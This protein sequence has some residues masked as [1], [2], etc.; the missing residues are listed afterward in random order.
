MA[1]R[2]QR[3]ERLEAAM[4]RQDT[5]DAWPEMN[6][7]MRRQTARVRL[8]VCRRLGVD[9][10]DFR[11]REAAALLIDDT[12]ALI[13]QDTAMVQRWCRQRGIVEDYRDA[14][15]RLHETI[16]CIADRLAAARTREPS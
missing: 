4:A 7:A 12:A 5:Q 16:E 13:A 9:P 10:D 1:N 6:A 2:Q 8:K 11:V 3:L 15:Q 14:R